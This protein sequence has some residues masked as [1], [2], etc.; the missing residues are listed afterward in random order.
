MSIQPAGK[1]EEEAAFLYELGRRV[2]NARHTAGLTRKQLAES[3]GL[4]ERYLAQLEAGEG[5]I[6]VL[7][8]RRVAKVLQTD[9]ERLV[10]EPSSR[11][12]SM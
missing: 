12:V 2:R 9:L 8:M 5:N 3:S 6:S 10:A 7:L 11:T 4:S 1:P